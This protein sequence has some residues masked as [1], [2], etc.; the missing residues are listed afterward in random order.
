M[1]EDIKYMMECIETLKKIT[2]NP[3]GDRPD[4]E[5][6]QSMRSKLGQI[7]EQ[8]GEKAETCRTILKQLED[9]AT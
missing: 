8:Y 3:T 6:M 1:E 9:D 5:T 2:A 7:H 4:V